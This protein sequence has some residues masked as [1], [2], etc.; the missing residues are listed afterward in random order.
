[1]ADIKAILVSSSQNPSWQ[2]STGGH[3]TCIDCGHVYR[4]FATVSLD[5]RNLHH[6][7]W[8]T[9]SSREV[10]E[11]KGMGRW[12]NKVVGI[13]RTVHDTHHHSSQHHKF[14]SLSGLQL[15]RCVNCL[16]LKEQDSQTI[17]NEAISISSS[18]GFSLPAT[19]I[20]QALQNGGEAVISDQGAIYYN[21]SQ[22]RAFI[23]DAK[24]GVPALA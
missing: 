11:H 24:F 15:R 8:T 7:T 13:K 17:A 5:G 22:F 23:T 6:N 20:I 14:R 12:F 4:H 19:S 21:P 2:Q 18:C 10:W 16:R 3:G 9:T 1:M